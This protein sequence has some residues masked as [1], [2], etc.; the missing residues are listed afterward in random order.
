MVQRDDG[1]FAL[2]GGMGACC[3]SET[4]FEF[5]KREFDFD[6]G[7]NAPVDE[8]KYVESLLDSK[9]KTLTLLF[10]YHYKNDDWEEAKGKWFSAAKIGELAR[11]DKIAFR[12]NRHIAK[13]ILDRRL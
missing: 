1:K 2:I 10:S 3:L 7:V 6:T 5:A 11:E 8:F 9:G 12:G 4:M 13:F